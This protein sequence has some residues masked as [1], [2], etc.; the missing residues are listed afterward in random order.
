MGILPMR[1]SLTMLLFD[2]VGRKHSY[3]RRHLLAWYR[4]NARDLPWRRTRDPYR[5]WLSEV[6]LQ[7]TRVQTALP[8]Y[9]RFTKAFPTI[10]D[11]AAASEDR[12]LKLWEGLGYY[13]RAHHLLR[14]ARILVNDYD[15]RFPRTAREWQRLPGV[16][17]YTASAIA[18]IAFGECVPVLDGNVKRVL[19]RLFNIRK[20]IDAPRTLRLLWSVAEVLVPRRS[21]GDFNQAMME[22]GAR[23]CT[24]P[25]PHCDKCPL[26][27]TCDAYALGRQTILPV[28]RARRSLP[29]YQIVAAAIRKNGRYLLGKRPAGGMLGG[30]WEFPGGKVEAGE[31]HDQSLG[32]EIREELGIEIALGPLVAVVVHTYSHFKMTLHLY[33]CRHIGGRP[34]PHYHSEIKWVPRSQFHNL[35]F[36]AA[37]LKL[38]RLL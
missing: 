14:G 29:H 5:V 9:V 17:R 11:L 24:P 26:R 2:Q 7:Q 12:V 16:G 15:T 23:T 21:P 1:C 37:D 31:T 36:P 35:A 13:G 27:K 25:A 22:L 3:I 19:A 38:L 32:R 33:R 6:L 28:R 30:L 34:Q 10:R 8:Y 4:R 20:S 18:S